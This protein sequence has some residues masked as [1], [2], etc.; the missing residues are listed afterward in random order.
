[1]AAST[2]ALRYDFPEFIR[3]PSVPTCDFS[4]AV[5]VRFPAGGPYTSG[6][7]NLRVHPAARQ[8]F[9]TLAAVML[10]F[11]YE[12]REGAGGTLSCRRITGGSGTTLHAHGVA[13]DWNPSK[14]AYR[15]S[16]GPIQWGR[17]TDMPLAMV[18]AIEAIRCING[19]ATWSWGGRWWNTKDPMHYQL[20]CRRS[21][22]ASGINLATLPVGAWK[23]YLEFESGGPV[24]PAPEDNVIPV[25]PST[26]RA[27]VFDL[28][29]A[30]NAAAVANL[31]PGFVPLQVDGR[32]GAG[33]KAAA[34]KW[35]YDAGLQSVAAEVAFD[36]ASV[37][38]LL[39]LYAPAP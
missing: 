37:G 21:S 26:V 27:I 13:G 8:A 11:G 20:G 25:D 22:L 4:G 30:L 38:A 15:F 28:Q 19:V 33:T 23:R 16:V 39:A 35:R 18:R 6:Y 31:W 10:W 17:H 9:R 29:R 34:D 5:R 32:A 14:N 24:S 7:I 1:M 12:F 2:A 36:A 3:N